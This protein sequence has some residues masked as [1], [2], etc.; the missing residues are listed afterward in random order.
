MLSHTAFLLGAYIVCVRGFIEQPLVYA[1]RYAE[2]SLNNRFIPYGLI[3][4]EAVLS[5][6]DDFRPAGFLLLI[7]HTRILLIIRTEAVLSMDDDFPPPFV[8]CAPR[9]NYESS[10]GLGF[11]LSS[12]TLNQTTTLLRGPTTRAPPG[13]AGDA[14]QARHK[15][16]KV[17]F[18]VMPLHRV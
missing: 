6:D 15:F 2:A 3:R 13:L 7:S 16:S 10:S 12:A 18:S 17:H 4:T 5:M 1:Y 11:R 9:T 8:F 14:T